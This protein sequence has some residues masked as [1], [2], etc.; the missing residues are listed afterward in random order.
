MDE[1]THS[2]ASDPNLQQDRLRLKWVINIARG[3]LL[4]DWELDP[5]WNARFVRLSNAIEDGDLRVR[6]D[7]RRPG[8]YKFAFATLVD[9]W[10]FVSKFPAERS[11]DWLRKFCLRWAAQRKQTL[12]DLPAAPKG[13]KRVRG[14][15]ALGAVIDLLTLLYPADIPREKTD[16]ELHGEV[17]KKLKEEDRRPVSL[18]TVRRARKAFEARKAA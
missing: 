13:S 9:L 11:L 3:A 1:S 7:S 14:T 5:L 17:L 18:T 8:V 4:K 6:Q 10:A 16:A 12:S 15:R 2:G